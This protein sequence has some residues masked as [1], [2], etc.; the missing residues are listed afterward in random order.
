MYIYT[1]TTR[2][3]LAMSKPVSSYLSLPAQPFLV[4][5]LHI[6]IYIYI[7]IYKLYIVLKRFRGIKRKKEERVLTVSCN[8]Y[9][10]STL[11]FIINGEGAN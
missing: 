6:Y 3:G 5:V 8:V 10:I 4:D 2:K 11:R 9:Q 1:E 7:Y